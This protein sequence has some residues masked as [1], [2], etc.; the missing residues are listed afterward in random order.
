MSDFWQGSVSTL[1]L[2]HGGDG[3]HLF[4]PLG[5]FTQK[6]PLTVVIPCL[7]ADLDTESMRG[8]VA[9]LTQLPWVSRVVVGLDAANEE[10]AASC[11]STLAGLGDR[12]TVLWWNDPSFQAP[13]AE[14]ASQVEHFPALGKGRNVWLCL[15]WLWQ[16]HTT[17]VVALLDSDIRD[18][19]AGMLARL[20][21]PVLR[22]D[23]DYRFC[24]GFY[25]RFTDRL[26]GRLTRLLVQPFLEAWEEIHRPSGL[27]EFL[28]AFRY[29]LSGEMAFRADLLRELRFPA[30][31]GMEI[32]ILGQ[33]FD[34]V[35][36]SSVCQSALCQ[37]YDHRH[38]S[39][40][41]EGDHGGLAQSAQEV[42]AALFQVLGNE[43]PSRSALE[44]AFRLRVCRALHHATTIA[45][46][47]GLEYS[48]EEESR[49]VKAFSRA[50]G[51]S[52]SRTV[53]WLPD[54]KSLSVSLSKH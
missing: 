42:A 30:D 39:L 7:A 11:R 27:S 29:P 20:V 53:P 3:S 35:P 15:G 5:E 23:L 28:R 17:G 32:G 46:M 47:N 13:L 14:I 4:G 54:W 16:N 31:Y 9:T 18:F 8:I 45:A 51:A 41:A 2:L 6:L 19:H 40:V 33:I 48:L 21:Y 38:Q 50:L 52:A 25:A 1:H 49:A 43:R 22:Q 10:Q 44:T 34:T 37:A 36:R 24:K 26:H 12:G